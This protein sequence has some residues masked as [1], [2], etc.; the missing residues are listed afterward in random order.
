MYS[1]FNAF[2]K[3]FDLQVFCKYFWL[4]TALFFLSATKMGNIIYIYDFFLVN[5]GVRQGVFFPHYCLMYI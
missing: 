5:N 4:S 1:Y 3:Y 2:Q